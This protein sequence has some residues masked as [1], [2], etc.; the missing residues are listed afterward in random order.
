[1]SVAEAALYL[2]AQEQLDA[3]RGAGTQACRYP[4]HSSERCSSRSLL[5]GLG[6]VRVVVRVFRVIRVVRVRVFRIVR[7]TAPAR[8]SPHPTPR[9][10]RHRR[11][12]RIRALSESLLARLSPRPRRV[13]GPRRAPA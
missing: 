5:A 4:S 1:M 12:M 2:P 3:A 8:L 10:P 11:A 6:A 13:A 9:R 7:V